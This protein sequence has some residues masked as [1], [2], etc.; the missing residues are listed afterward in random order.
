MSSKS[1]YCTLC[2]WLLVIHVSAGFPLEVL[3]STVQAIFSF[4]TSEHFSNCNLK[5]SVGRLVIL[6]GNWS[7]LFLQ[8]HSYDIALLLSIAR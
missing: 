3:K 5:Y 4:F 8:E 2:L 6:S 1:I 7:F